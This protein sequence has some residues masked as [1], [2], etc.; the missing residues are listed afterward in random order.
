[1]DIE[2]L[3]LFDISE[4]SRRKKYKGQPGKLCA[5]CKHI[6]AVDHP[7]F[8]R[9]FYCRQQIANNLIGHKEIRKYDHSCFMFTSGQAT[10]QRYYRNGRY[11]LKEKNIGVPRLVPRRWEVGN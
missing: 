7:Y 11:S 8:Q 2:Y 10:I 6:F 4:V 3:H 5:E 9:K 1:M